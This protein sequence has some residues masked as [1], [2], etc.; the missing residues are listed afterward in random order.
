[1]ADLLIR[2]LP[3]ALHERLKARAIKHRRSVAKEVLLVLEEAMGI[4]ETQRLPPVYIGDFPLTDAWLAT[5]RNPQQ[6]TN[7]QTKESS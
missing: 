3:D 4:E 6:Q 7:D 2:D 5:V 1:M